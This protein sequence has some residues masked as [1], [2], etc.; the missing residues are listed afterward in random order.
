MFH[1][2][3]FGSYWQVLEVQ[4]TYRRSTT[5]CSFNLIHVRR[6]ADWHQLLPVHAQRK[7]KKKKNNWRR[8]F[9]SHLCLLACLLAYKQQRNS[10]G[11]SRHKTLNPSICKTT[12]MTS[13]V[14]VQKDRLVFSCDKFRHTE[15]G[16]LHTMT[17]V[18]P[19]WL[20]LFTRDNTDFEEVPR[21][22]LV[23]LLTRSDTKQT[24]LRENSFCLDTESWDLT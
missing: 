13:T 14:G 11:Y 6:T 3:T 4:W 17:V 7:T 18:F 8:T 19:Q 2:W 16:T 21:L 10:R 23:S 20:C 1:L 12:G 9:G 5:W 15:K 22:V 24:L